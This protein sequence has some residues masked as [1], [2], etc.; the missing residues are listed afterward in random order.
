MEF[1]PA[2]YY[3]LVYMLIIMAFAI[4]VCARYRS[5]TS[6]RILI[7]SR[8]PISKSLLFTILIIVYIGIRPNS[9]IF[10]DG[11]GYWY[12]ILDHRWENRTMEEVS[13]QFATKYLMSTLSSMN[14][15]PRIGFF[16]FAII[17]YGFALLAMRKMFP[18]D[19]LLAMIM[20][21]GAFCTFGGAVNGIKNGLALSLFLCAIAYRD[22]WKYY[23]PFLILSIG[24]HHSMQLSIAAFFACKFYKKTRVYYALWFF[25][26]IIAALHITYFQTFFADYTDES[27]QGYLITD[28]DSW[29]T[30][31]RPD[32][33]LYSAAPLI[34]G[35]WAIKKKR[36]MHHDYTFALNVYLVMNTIWL[37]CMYSAF[38]NR[39]AALSWAIFPII[40][41]YP[42]LKIPTSNKQYKYAAYAVW[43][44]LIF[45][46]YMTLNSL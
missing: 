3:S 44:Q 14:V 21:C 20:F 13:N 27:G 26:I 15:N 28:S 19:T 23:I 12:G 43:G 30:G 9:P 10:A 42:F 18:K 16:T 41:L 8:E 32:F 36:L 2:Q 33:V 6:K 37:L 25:G 29:V 22:N 11:P 24:F 17:Y 34:V 4:P 38:T 1:I 35:W 45:T 46:T 5:Y 40:L 7:N 31:F 39:I